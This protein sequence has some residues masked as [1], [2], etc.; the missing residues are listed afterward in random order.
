MPNNNIVLYRKYRPQ[1]FGELIGQ[2]HIRQTLENQIKEGKVA[3]AYLFSGPRGLGKT[4]TA[5]LLAKALN[6]HNRKQ[7]KAEPCGNCEACLEITNGRSLDVLE[8]DAASHTGVDN[9][10]ENII[11]TTRFTPIRLKYKIFIIDEVHML[12]ISAFNA[13]LK[14]LEEPPE[15]VIFIL[16]TTEL[17]KV[18]ETIISR[19]QK[20]DFKKVVPEKIIKRLK[21][22]SKKEGIETDDQV[23]EAV[24]YRAEGCIRDADSLLEQIF[25]LVDP[26]KKKI[27]YE[28]ASLVLPHSDFTYIFNLVE[29]LINGEK[30]ESLKLVNELAIQGLDLEHFIRE[31]IEFLRKMMLCKIDPA[32]AEYGP[33][34]DKKTEE[35]L[36][37]LAEKADLEKIKAMI[38]VMI[39]AR[40]ELKAAEIP[41]FPLEL[42][43]MT[44]INQT[45]DNPGNGP[46]EPPKNN[47]GLPSLTNQ[48]LNSKSKINSPQNNHS[49]SIRMDDINQKWNIVLKEIKNFNYSLSAFLR[50]GKIKELNGDTLSLEFK[51][52][53]YRDRIRDHKR[54]I[55]EIL[56]KTL[57]QKIIL[58]PQLAAPSK[59]ESKAESKLKPKPEED[60]NLP[61][62][63]EVFGG[64]VME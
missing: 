39:R 58:S 24:A 59:S 20:F 56:E 36:K 33:S 40:L 41:Q 34:L 37:K 14:I 47:P 53:F 9:V 21:E 29:N 25:A 19:C 13:L 64:E 27:K 31:L 2:E 45:S 46:K 42:A 30:K 16:A 6:C 32:L 28:E 26:K 4:T 22:I 38:E 12:S 51:Y 10:R 50:L 3:H 49:L 23:L 44:I 18:P 35:N 5:R 52:K 15:Y 43:V 11:E 7:G 60:D 54:I 63:L 48:N 57:G 55:E 1:T 62:L 8:I 61:Q 17:H